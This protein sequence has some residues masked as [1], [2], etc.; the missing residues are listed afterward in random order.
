MLGP[1]AV[2]SPGGSVILPMGRERAVLAQ[3]LVSV[4]RRAG[5]D[6]LVDGLWPQTPPASAERTLHA[7][8]ARLRRR[9]DPERSAG[10]PGLIVT[11][12][13][14]YLLDIDSE[15]VDAGRFEAH[16]DRAVRGADESTDLQGA[17]QLWRG[18]A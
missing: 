16:G 14:G 10:R 1:L 4:G 3:L 9:L 11:V 12:G 6:A 13:R 17:L 15:H 2:G 5:V 18:R 7:H 8:V